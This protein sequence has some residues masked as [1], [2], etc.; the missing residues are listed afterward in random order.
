MAIFKNQDQSNNFHYEIE[1]SP[2]LE[3]K[4]LLIKC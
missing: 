2:K 1:Y 3:L 4:D